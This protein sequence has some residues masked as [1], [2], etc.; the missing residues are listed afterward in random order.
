[1]PETL[2]TNSPKMSEPIL[3]IVICTFNRVKLL[4]SC[5]SGLMS[6]TIRQQIQVIVVDDGSSQD[7]SS[8]VEKFDV[9]F[10]ALE[11]NQGLSAAR[12]AGIAI[13]RASII[14]FTDDDVIVPPDWCESLFNA[15]NK[16][17][18]GTYAIGGT[19]TVAEVSSL[20]QRYLTHHNPLSPI[21]L[22]VAHAKTF[23]GR[24]RA[25]VRSESGTNQTTRPVYSLVGANMSFTR[26]ALDAVG[27]FDP[28]IRFGGDEE[29]VCV[30]LRRQFGDQSIVC[31]PSIAV[32]HNFDPRFRDTMR[33]AFQYG[34]SSGRSWARTGGLPSLRPV[35]GLFVVSLI[36]I[37]PFS[38]VGAMVISLLIP[39]SLW[40][41]WIKVSFCDRK[42]EAMMYP[43]LA[44]TQELSSNVGLLVG[45]RKELQNRREIRNVEGSRH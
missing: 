19:V 40:H 44:L 8:V 12:N 11:S 31:Y 20:T 4:S 34:F 33:R 32:A 38:I 13:A 10:V 23:M 2:D 16:A 15:W 3:S 25:Y 42:P 28:S 45:W 5:L 43:L 41:R 37:A 9:D 14:A 21:D 24:L 36:V 27:G 1:M 6:Q 17:P 29:L 22:D 39:F 26:K 18:A 35:G 30:N 7:T